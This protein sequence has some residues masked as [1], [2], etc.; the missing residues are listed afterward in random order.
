MVDINDLS[1]SLISKRIISYLNE[2]QWTYKKS[3]QDIASI[4]TKSIGG[5]NFNALVPIDKTMGDFTAKMDE[6]FDLL[7]RVDGKTKEEIVKFFED[8][9]VASQK[10]GREVLDIRIKSVS[11]NKN[12]IPIEEVGL[13]LKSLQQLFYQIGKSV[14]NKD[15]TKESLRLSLIDTYKGS[16]GLKLASPISRQL[17]LL[18]SPLIETSFE[19]LLELIEISKITDNEQLKNKMPEFEVET[20]VELKHLMSNILQLEADTVWNWG[21]LNPN[22]GGFVN[23]YVKDVV[24]FLDIIAE[25]KSQERIIIER[26]GRLVVGGVGNGKKRRK[27]VFTPLDEDQDDVT[28][29]ISNDLINKNQ[30]VITLGKLSKVVIEKIIKTKSSGEFKEEYTLIDLQDLSTS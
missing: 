16:F 8:V 18:D 29:N 23:L 30:N 27:F 5:K 25:E 9:S 12:E 7:A 6:L 13:V 22:K 11:G 1:Y 15:D 28:G 10:I 4:W 21:S 2:N 24:R 14:T 26:I 20:L 19:Q 17:E 3:V